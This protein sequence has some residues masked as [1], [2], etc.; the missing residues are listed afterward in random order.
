MIKL[1]PDGYEK[2]CCNCGKLPNGDECWICYGSGK[3]PK[4]Y[5]DDCE[6]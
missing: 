4:G 6:E 3:V 1:I 2:C 5:F